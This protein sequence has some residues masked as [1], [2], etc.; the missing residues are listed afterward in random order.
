VQYFKKCPTSTTTPRGEI[1]LGLGCRVIFTGST[2]SEGLYPFSI[3]FEDDTLPALHAAA[4]SLVDAQAWVQTIQN[5]MD[6]HVDAGRGGSKLSE[7]SIDTSSD[8]AASEQSTPTSTH[9]QKEGSKQLLSTPPQPKFAKR[10]LRHRRRQASF[11]VVVDS[12]DEDDEGGGGVMPA[13]VMAAK[14]IARSKSRSARPTGKAETEGV[15]KTRMPAAPSAAPGQDWARSTLTSAHAAN[16]A[17]PLASH[18]AFHA[19]P[20]FRRPAAVCPN[21]LTQGVPAHY[22]GLASYLY[23]IC[24]PRPADWTLVRL[25]NRVRIFRDN[26]PTPGCMSNSE[27]A[28]QPLLTRELV[29]GRPSLIAQYLLD[30]G[31]ARRNWDVSFSHGCVLNQEK[32][33]ASDTGTMGKE[34]AIAYTTRPLALVPPFV[35]PQIAARSFCVGRFS[36]TFANGCVLIMFDSASS[37]ARSKSSAHRAKSGEVKA[38]MR[39]GFWIS[40]AAPNSHNSSSSSSTST[41]TS[42]SSSRRRRSSSNDT[43]WRV[44]RG[45]RDTIGASIVTMFL[46]IDA[47][48]WVGAGSLLGSM[49]HAEGYLTE[50]MLMAVAGLRNFVEKRIHVMGMPSLPSLSSSLSSSLVVAPLPRIDTALENNTSAGVATAPSSSSS[51]SSP[52]ASS[53]TATNTATPATVADL[54]L[55][56]LQAMDADICSWSLLDHVEGS[57]CQTT[58]D[59]SVLKCWSETDATIFQLRGPNYLDDRVKVPSSPSCLRLVAC[60]LTMRRGGYASTAGD[61]NTGD[62]PNPVERVAWMEHGLVQRVQRKYGDK[63]PFLFVINFMIPGGVNNI[64]YFRVPDAAGPEDA[65]TCTAVKM[66]RKYMSLDVDDEYRDARL[67]IIPNVVEGGWVVKRG[68]GNKPAIIGKKITQTYHAGANWF[69]IDVDIGSS[70]VAGAILGL[71]KGYTKVLVID[72]AFLLE[73]KSAEELPERMLGSARYF[74]INLDE[75]AEFPEE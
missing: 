54:S 16:V 50:H 31:D 42:T 2:D 49:M 24:I 26:N 55:A 73:S 25:A 29:L 18:D 37:M 41:S 65:G 33:N 51:P 71:V 72:I 67:K 21:V 34:D 13:H 38:K 22:H 27:Y 15:K 68:V 58:T 52:A 12:G 28:N 32:K 36:K 57:K 75:L 70:R 35:S 61:A 6:M 59:E 69:E 10:L 23:D 3:V 14:A 60:D 44:Q 43:E 17:P 30:V 53:A 46:Q 39:G 4:E 63:A 66:L 56:E 47:Q 7:V 1:L 9:D 40:P 11:I 64:M 48:G 20:S 62:V 74:R 5:N 45:A 8:G 19:S